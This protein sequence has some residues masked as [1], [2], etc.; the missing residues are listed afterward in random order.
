MFGSRGVDPFEGPPHFPIRLWPQVRQETVPVKSYYNMYHRQSPI[1]R[2]DKTSAD[3]PGYFTIA[4]R[5]EPNYFSSAPY[6]LTDYFYSATPQ[7]KVGGKRRTN[8]RR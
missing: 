5:P 1:S 7:V 6:G 4:G 3:R 2:R 8:R